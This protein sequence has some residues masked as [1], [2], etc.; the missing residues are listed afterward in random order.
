VGNNTI[1][2]AFV[3]VGGIVKN[4]SPYLIISDSKA[5]SESNL[6]KNPS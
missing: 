3:A 5:E 4:D 6:S 2:T 1:K